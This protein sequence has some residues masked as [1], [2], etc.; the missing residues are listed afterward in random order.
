MLMARDFKG[1][2]EIAVYART[3]DVRRVVEREGVIQFPPALA[4]M[5]A[6]TPPLLA[7][8]ATSSRAADGS[9]V[10]AVWRPRPVRAVCGRCRDVRPVFGGAAPSNGCVARIFVPPATTR[11]GTAQRAIPTFALNRY[12]ADGCDRDGRAPLLG[13]AFSRS[14][15]GHQ[16]G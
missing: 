10:G 2:L 12:D 4:G 14:G 3:V 16:K 7:T 6:S 15:R 13:E 9:G 11:A 8:S 5:Q 1:G